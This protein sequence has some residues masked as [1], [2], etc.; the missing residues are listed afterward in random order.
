MTIHVTL[1]LICIHGAVENFLV[2]GV[3]VPNAF[4]KVSP[5]QGVYIHP[6]TAFLDW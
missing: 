2:S 4:G 3:D 1:P 6:N 5:N